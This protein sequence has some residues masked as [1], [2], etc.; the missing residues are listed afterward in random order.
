MATLIVL[1]VAPIT[2]LAA[3]RTA[4]AARDFTALW[5]AGRLAAQHAT[6][7]LADPALFTGQLR[8]W[9]GP[10]MPDQIWPYPPPTLL[11]AAPLAQLPLAWS[12]LVYTSA[13]LLLL[14]CTLRAA[15]LPRWMCIA[16]LLSP[17]VADDV[18]IG[19]NGA[20]TAACLAGG[21]LLL[22]TQPL[23]GGALLGALILKPQLGLLLPICLIAG[24]RWR[25]AGAALA[26]SAALAGLAW[27][28][29]GAGAWTDYLVSAR[30]AIQT[31]F[32]APWDPAGPQRIFASV[33]M[34]ARSLGASLATAYAAQF[35]ASL[36]CASLAFRAW[37]SNAVPR[38]RMAFTVALTC[39]ASPWVHSYDMPAL[40]VA[41]VTIA[42]HARPEHRPFLALAW[43]WPAAL[44]WTAIPNALLVASTV[45]V[46]A[47]AW[48]PG[49]Q[50]IRHR[51]AKALV[52]TL[53][54]CALAPASFAQGVEKACDAAA[55]SAERDWNVP[56]GVLSA[57]GTVESGRQHGPLGAAPWPWTINAAG[58]GFFF[59]SKAA[60][61]AAV[62]GLMQQGYPFI[63]IGCFQ[64]DI[65]YHP[66]LFRSLED[67]FD[68]ERNAQA[69][70]RLLAFER[71]RVPD[72]AT[73]V[74]HYHSVTP[75][76][77]FPYLQRVR[78]ALPSAMLR[79]KNA[80][81]LADWPVDETRSTVVLP[82]V[83][84]PTPPPRSSH[85]PQIVFIGDAERLPQV[86]VSAIDASRLQ[87]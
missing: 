51:W 78:A 71:A 40:A 50:G 65:A 2:G 63:D 76:L 19:Q 47:I 8:A 48:R 72:W 10:G 27:L 58:R 25:A 53:V 84:Y 14:W 24:A 17:A 54:L 82:R 13:T 49:R 29:F 59:E 28:C 80:Q 62:L 61:I 1:W 75:E 67:A 60:A 30:P 73:A 57:V 11:L 23:L 20:L 35:L 4:V 7:I 45:S 69:A 16:T 18:L 34:A 74:A 68:P 79:G 43:C 64:I 56:A 81:T 39:L 38:R 83:V 41:I 32:E 44:V 52:V 33:F 55:A 37:R 9:F 87:R 3:D 21:L 66:D 46:A 77:G 42:P 6:A 22:D 12:F 31:Y 85:G 70:A 86:I 26:I 5:A 15:L 36:A